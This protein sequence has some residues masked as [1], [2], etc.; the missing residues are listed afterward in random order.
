MAVLW[1]DLDK[2]CLIE[3]RCIWVH[4][5][6][7]YG[8]ENIRA[9]DIPPSRKSIKSQNSLQIRDMV[10]HTFET[11]QRMFMPITDDLL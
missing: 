7:T 10:L 8:R 6:F 2:C 4:E 5:R 3:K 1:R 9:A 11:F